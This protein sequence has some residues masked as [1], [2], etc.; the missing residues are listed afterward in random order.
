[1]EI[2]DPIQSWMGVQAIIELIP[3]Q[4]LKITL[5]GL[6]SA[7]GQFQNSIRSDNGT[8]Y[9]TLQRV[10]KFFCAGTMERGQTINRSD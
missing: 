10:T 8:K 1:M 4:L 2:G 3:V 5:S 7:I 9:P 6:C